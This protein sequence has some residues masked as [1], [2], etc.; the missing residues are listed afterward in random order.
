MK[1]KF[2]LLLL[3]MVASLSVWA[4][5][6]DNFSQDHEWVDLGLPSGTLWATMNIGASSPEEYGDYFAW[7]ETQ[8]KEVYNWSTYSWSNGDYFKLTKYCNNSGYGDNGFTDDKTELDPDD[9]AAY[10][11]WGSEWRMPTKAQQDELISECTW[12][13]TTR[14]DVNG[15]LV[16]SNHNSASLFLPATGYLWGGLLYDDGSSGRYWSRMLFISYSYPYN[17]H[18]LYFTSDNVGWY[19]FAQRVFGFSVRAVCENSQTGIDEINA[20]SD[21]SDQRYNMM[22]QPVGND[23][24]GI[25]IE[26]GK[27]ILVK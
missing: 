7:G 8:P 15:Y 2:F 6:K 14:N 4:I 21:K 25:V 12:Q 9:D 13:W 17:A 22:G 26:N 3:A 20:T 1:S 19:T 5:E 18:F 11:N 23:Y 16:T 24:K 10:V 27:K